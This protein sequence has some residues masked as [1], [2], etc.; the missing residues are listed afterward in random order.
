MTSDLTAVDLEGERL[1]RLGRYEEALPILNESLRLQRSITDGAPNS[2]VLL[3]V[4]LNN[5]GFCLQRLKQHR[6]AVSSLQEA[7]QLCEPLWKADQ[8]NDAL[9]QLM[10]NI[11]GALEFCLAALGEYE[12]AMPLTELQVRLQRSLTTPG[13]L[14]IDVDL[15]KALRLFASL[16][17]RV[18]L[19]GKEAHS[20]ASE[21]LVIF[22]HLVQQDPELYTHELNMT[23]EV[24]AETLAMVGRHEDAAVVRSHVVVEYE[25]RAKKMDQAGRHEDAA[26]LR[27]RQKYLV[28][29]ARKS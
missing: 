18:S 4:R 1:L 26:A 16:R 7:R 21:A 9:R 17:T 6:L 12:E 15:A 11:L 8:G 10:A 13:P 28:G 25:A 23:Y 24:F 27:A 2:A 29:L 22:Q 19:E 5:L 3:A 14:V 20:A